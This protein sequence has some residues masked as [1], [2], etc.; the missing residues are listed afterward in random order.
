MP[1]GV[2]KLAPLRTNLMMADAL[3]KGLPTPAHAKLRAVMMG[4]AP[5]SARVFQEQIG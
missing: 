1:G 2:L 3:A 4:H 5:S